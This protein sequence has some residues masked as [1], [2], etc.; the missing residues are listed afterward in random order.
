MLAG[1]SH[2]F[3]TVRMTR[4]KQSSSL[5]YAG[6]SLI[7]SCT[8]RPPCKTL[9]FAR[10]VTLLPETIFRPRSSLHLVLYPLFFLTI[11][12]EKRVLGKKHAGQSRTSPL[13]RLPKFRQSSMPTFIPPLINILSNAELQNAE[14]R[15]AGRFPMQRPAVFRSQRRSAISSHKAVSS[16][17]V[18]CSP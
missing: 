14:G 17:S 2:T 9:L 12:S 7:Y 10:S 6:V 8:V 15:R 11:L 13:D 18:I 5:L 3:L 1:L 16:R 4:S